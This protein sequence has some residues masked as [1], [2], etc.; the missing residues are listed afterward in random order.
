MFDQYYSILIEMNSFH[1]I[2]SRFYWVL[3]GFTG[4]FLVLSIRSFV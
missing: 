1:S 4:L 3:L 2:F